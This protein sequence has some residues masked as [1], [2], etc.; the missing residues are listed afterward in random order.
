MQKFVTKYQ[1][2]VFIFISI[3]YG[4]CWRQETELHGFFYLSQCGHFQIHIVVK[5]IL[6][7]LVTKYYSSNTLQ[8]LFVEGF[9]FMFGNSVRP[10]DIYWPCSL[11]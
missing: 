4:R 5:E 2:S 11:S 7:D 9:E 3:A 1:T 8:L 6:R 10:T